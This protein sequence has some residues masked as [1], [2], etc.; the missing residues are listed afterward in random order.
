MR[1]V[2]VVFK[3]EFVLVES[4]N[5]CLGWDVEDGFKVGVFLRIIWVFVLLILKEFI[6][7]WWGVLLVFYFERVVLM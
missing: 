2:V 6:L 3:V 4:I 5:N 1:L 7:V